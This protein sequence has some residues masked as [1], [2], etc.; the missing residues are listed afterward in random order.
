[1]YTLTMKK[2]LYKI[3][4]YGQ[5]DSEYDRIREGYIITNVEKTPDEKTV[6][7]IKPTYNNLPCI[8]IKRNAIPKLDSSFAIPTSSVCHFAFFFTKQ[9]DLNV[10]RCWFPYENKLLEKNCHPLDAN[11]KYFLSWGLM[12]FNDNECPTIN[13]IRM[14]D[15]DY[16]LGY[17]LTNFGRTVDLFNFNETFK[18]HDDQGPF[19]KYIKTQNERAAIIVGNVKRICFKMSKSDIYIH[20]TAIHDFNK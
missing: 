1:M 17:E 6:L 8:G 19:D 18:Y 5:P 16:A 13:K 7:L 20:E 12:N 11:G 2:A 4:Y 10:L 9:R 15:Y 14:N 3:Q